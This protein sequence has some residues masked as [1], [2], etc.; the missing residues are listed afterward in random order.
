MPVQ[1][2][3][4]SVSQVWIPIEITAESPGTARIPQRDAVSSI[5]WCQSWHDHAFSI[6]TSV[7]SNSYPGLGPGRLFMLIYGFS[8]VMIEVVEKFLVKLLRKF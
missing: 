5:Q 7:T 1:K 6:L 4:Q 8:V 3:P 2:K